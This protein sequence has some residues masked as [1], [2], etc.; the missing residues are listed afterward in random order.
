MNEGQILIPPP[1]SIAPPPPPPQF[2]PPSPSHTP[3]HSAFFG[4]PD[5]PLD[6]AAL[7]PPSMRP[8]KPPAPE[9]REPPTLRPPLMTPPK[10]P[11]AQMAISQDIPE[12]P[13]FTPPLP[14][15]KS[16][17]IKK[18]PPEK[19]TRYSSIPNL[20]IIPSGPTNPTTSHTGRSASIFNLQNPSLI[21]PAMKT[22]PLTDQ[23][24]SGTPPVPPVKPS[25]RNSSGMRLESDLQDLRQNLQKMLPN[26]TK[27][28]SMLV[29]GEPQTLREIPN[30]GPNPKKGLLTPEHFPGELSARHLTQLSTT[31]SYSPLLSRKL[32]NLKPNEGSSLKEPSASPLALLMAAKERD[33]HRSGLSRQNS[34]KST[35]SIDSYSA[36]IYPNE[37]RANSISITKP[38]LN[39][40]RL[41]PTALTMPEPTRAM[42]CRPE[43]PLP[44]SSVFATTTV[45]DTSAITSPKP[46]SPLHAYSDLTDGGLSFIPPPPEF[47]NSDPEDASLDLYSPNSITKVSP[48]INFISKSFQNTD[49]YNPSPIA[50][51]V[52][53]PSTPQPTVSVE[54]QPQTP[55]Y[56]PPKNLPPSPPKIQPPLAPILPPQSLPPTL[57]KPQLPISLLPQPPPSIA[58]NQTTLLS[59]L[60]KKMLEMDSKFSHTPEV[61][62]EWD[63]EDM[64]A[65]HQI[66]S[67]P[68]PGTLLVQSKGLNMT[69]LQNKVSQKAQS[70]ATSSR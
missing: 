68:K 64:G 23:V 28:P 34:T 26:Q 7:E 4:E 39:Q 1:P 70:K 41:S 37:S 35:N 6:L 8:P 20:A 52:Y 30:P 11:T 50:S 36:S 69:E 47:A 12:C 17:I 58:P 62:S 15:S 54:K 32:R 63:D 33:K 29:N 46:L 59:I 61:H 24:D 18:R 19:P 51:V 5:P 2:I 14:P 10:P 55:L 25:R 42:L 44:S 21:Q 49:I 22:S 38:H 45:I 56:S 16:P 13:K 3:P 67:V 65:S 40:T 9:N 43:Q 57:S 27:T 60:Q 53:K 48:S 66:N 31:S